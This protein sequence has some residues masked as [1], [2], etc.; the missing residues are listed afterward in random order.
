MTAERN[1]DETCIILLFL[2]LQSRDLVDWGD[3]NTL[4]NQKSQ[5]L[6]F[7]F[8]FHYS[9]LGYIENEML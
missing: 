5:L 8:T 9:I 1:S 4:I 6:N 2:L 7:F 3:H